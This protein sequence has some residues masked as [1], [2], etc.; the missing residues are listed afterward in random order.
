[1]L[2]MSSTTGRKIC[3]Y[4]E[5]FLYAF[6][7][8]QEGSAEIHLIASVHLTYILEENCV[9]DTT[10]F[11]QDNTLNADILSL[12]SW[13]DIYIWSNELSYSELIH[14]GYNNPKITTDRSYPN[15]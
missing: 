13:W 11:D 12:H 9:K 14:T 10:I 7:I 2:G 3:S 5:V 8:H 4:F 15:K 6:L 1:M